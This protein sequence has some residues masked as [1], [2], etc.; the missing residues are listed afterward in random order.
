MVS[1]PDL[2]CL[3][4]GTRYSEL[5]IHAAVHKAAGTIRCSEC[6]QQN[7]D[8]DAPSL[9]EIC[10]EARPGLRD[11]CPRCK[12][13]SSPALDGK[14]RFSREVGM[15]VHPGSTG[16]EEGNVV[17]DDRVGRWWHSNCLSIIASTFPAIGTIDGRNWPKKEKVAP[18]TEGKLVQRELW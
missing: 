13:N 15:W 5:R 17:W 10:D 18:K 3:V 11:R 8:L 16:H 14:A 4:C 1:K 7:P 9:Y 6:G 12:K 2:V